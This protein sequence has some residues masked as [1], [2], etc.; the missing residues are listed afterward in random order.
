METSLCAIVEFQRS[1]APKVGRVIKFNHDAEHLPYQLNGRITQATWE[2]FM[3]DVDVLAREH[4]YVQRP[5]AGDVAKW[6]LC[7]LLGSVVGV[8]CMNPDSGN[9]QNWCENVSRVTAR[10]ERDFSQGGCRMSLQKGVSYYI[11]IDIDPSA[12]LVDFGGKVPKGNPQD[13]SSYLSPFQSMPSDLKAMMSSG[14]VG[15]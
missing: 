6:G 10:Y 1:S 9:Y 3:S 13:G 7:A 15:N 2:A 8:C 11:R 14:S 4:P 5:G 12:E